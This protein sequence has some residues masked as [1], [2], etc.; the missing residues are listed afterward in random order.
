LLEKS[1]TLIHEVAARLAEFA[2]VPF[3]KTK[4]FSHNIDFEFF[5][6]VV[7]CGG[8]PRGEARNFLRTLSDTKNTAT[9]L[10]Q[11][12]EQVRG[13]LEEARN[14]NVKLPDWQEWWRRLLFSDHSAD[15]GVLKH[16]QPQLVTDALNAL[17]ALTK[18]LNHIAPL[19]AGRLRGTKAY[20]G[21]AELVFALER[22]AL[23]QGGRFTLNKRDRKGSLIQAI[24]WLRAYC[25]SDQERKWLADCLPRAN[26]HPV[27][28]YESA[29]HR[30]R[31]EARAR[32]SHG[33]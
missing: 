2:K 19:R 10:L 22:E 16:V 11:Q 23:L 8:G 21:L 17:S 9:T 5:C 3:L 18:A 24:D 7:E 29:I 30:A 33:N 20:P 6:W 12:L 31:V 4:D 1:Q 26:R 25:L 28:M 13:R 15:F 32:R 14:P 27:A